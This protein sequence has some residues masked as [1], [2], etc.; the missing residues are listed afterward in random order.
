[1]WTAWC[2]AGATGNRRSPSFVSTIT[3]PDAAGRAS[4]ATTIPSGA[5]S[6][7]YGPTSSFA[8]AARLPASSVTA[9]TITALS[10]AAPLRGLLDWVGEHDL[11]GTRRF[12]WFT[13]AVLRRAPGDFAGV[14]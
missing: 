2:S 3:A 6:R 5:G 4:H 8:A 7:R 1:M 13:L 9:A 10:D 12:L 14:V 11:D